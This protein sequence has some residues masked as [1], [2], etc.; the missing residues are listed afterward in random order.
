ME[1]KAAAGLRMIRLVGALLLA[2]SGSLTR[3]GAP[4]LTAL[5]LRLDAGRRGSSGSRAVSVEA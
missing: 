1:L 4:Q 5:P 3:V 2:R